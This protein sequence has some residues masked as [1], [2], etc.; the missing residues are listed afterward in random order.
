MVQKRRAVNEIFVD[1][2][3]FFFLE[4]EGSSSVSCAIWNQTENDVINKLANGSCVWIGLYRH[5]VWS[6][7]SNTVFKHWA[8]NQP[9]QG[10]QK[11]IAASFSDSGRWSDETCSQSFPFVKQFKLYSHASIQGST[12][13]GANSNSNF[14][15]LSVKNTKRLT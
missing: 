5:K 1:S 11:C 3:L 8:E 7:G 12:F 2:F 10:D 13:T 9:D 15:Y 4:V 6:D 14:I